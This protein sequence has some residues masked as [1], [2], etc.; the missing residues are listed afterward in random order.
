MLKSKYIVGIAITFVIISTTAC[1]KSDINILNNNS[2]EINS[3][4]ELLKIYTFINTAVEGTFTYNST[5]NFA[6]QNFAR[7]NFFSGRFHSSAAMGNLGAVQTGNLLKIGDEILYPNADKIYQKTYQQVDP[8]WGS[9]KDISLQETS[10]SPIVKTTF[11]I[12]QLIEVENYNPLQVGQPKLSIN[13]VVKVKSDNANTK[14]I[15]VTVEYQPAYNDSLRMAG[16]TEVIRNVEVQNDDGIVEL[17]RSLFENIPAKCSYK[18]TLGRVN[19]QIA[20]TSDGKKYGLYAY[21]N[22]SN[23]YTNE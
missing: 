4:A 10:T 18:L 14:G 20:E 11:R 21:L 19:Y 9:S 13:G 2:T 12:P 17:S 15:L 3:D 23:F 22:L 5:G 8:I 1:R 16:Y 6:S 7:N